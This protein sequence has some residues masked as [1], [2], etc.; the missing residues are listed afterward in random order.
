VEPPVFNLQKSYKDSSITTPLIFVL[1]TGSDPVAD[2]NRF[3]EKMNMSKKK[4]EIS[5]GRGMGPQATEMI[6]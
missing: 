3:A 2:F 4:D 5:L 6:E 1:S